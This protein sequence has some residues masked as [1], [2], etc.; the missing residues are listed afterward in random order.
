MGVLGWVELKKASLPD[1]DI[2]D[3]KERL[4]E[5]KMEIDELEIYWEI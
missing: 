3:E 5:K 1:T 2:Q 4:R